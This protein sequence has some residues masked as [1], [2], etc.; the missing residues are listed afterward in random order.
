[1][2][3]NINTALAY[4]AERVRVFADDAFQSPQSKEALLLAIQRAIASVEYRLGLRIE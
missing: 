4:Q 2:T 3:N 1:M